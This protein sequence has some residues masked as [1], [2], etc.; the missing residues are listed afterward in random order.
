MLALIAAI[1]ILVLLYTQPR[2]L[3]AAAGHWVGRVLLVTLIGL[4][5]F[6]HPA[7]GVLAVVVYIASMDQ[8]EGMTVA[9][10]RHN[11]CR[12]DPDGRRRLVDAA[13]QNVSMD[14]IKDTYPEVAFAGK[15]CNPCDSDCKFDLL[16]T[17][18]LVQ[19]RSIAS[20]SPTQITSTQL[21]ENDLSSEAKK[22]KLK[23]PDPL[24]NIPG[25]AA[26]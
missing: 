11:N 18:A 20:S 5:A 1:L 21:L 3:G 13:D 22:D 23:T 15:P 25:E 12:D 6:V 26:A 9:G 14:H 7:V 10:F 19:G 16:E 2:I 4:C 8:R 17:E 24:P